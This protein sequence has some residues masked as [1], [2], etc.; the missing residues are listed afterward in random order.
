[1]TTDI[2]IDNYISTKNGERIVS[3]YAFQI[4]GDEA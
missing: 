1:M 3:T 2:V 4:N